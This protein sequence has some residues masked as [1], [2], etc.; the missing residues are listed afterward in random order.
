MVPIVWGMPT[1]AT[2]ERYE[3]GEVVL[4]GCCISADDP[5]AECT[6]CGW[7][8]KRKEPRWT[9]SGPNQFLEE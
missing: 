9:G 5:V 7:R 2:V 4:G 8:R 6:T 3:R 1:M